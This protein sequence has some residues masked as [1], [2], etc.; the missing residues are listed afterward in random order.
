V[1][2]D[3]QEISYRELNERANRLARH[4]I[5]LGVGPE[6]LVG[7]CFERSVEMVV[8]LIAVSKAGAAWLPL[9]PEY[10]ERRLARIVEAARPKLVLGREKALNRLPSE[11]PCLSLDDPALV[12]AINA[13]CAGVNSD[14]V[15]TLAPRH[16]A[17]VIFTS[18]ST[19][20]PQGV[21]VTHA[22][23]A[24]LAATQSEH[25]R[26]TPRSR[27]LQF[28]SLNFD[29]SVWEMLMAL[30]S[31]ATL[32]LLNEQQRSGPALRE[33]LLSQRITHA[34]LP[35]AVL[36]TLNGD[37]DEAMP[38]ETLV[39]AGEACP[40]ELAA[41]W[42]RRTRMFNAYGPTETTIC[43]T[44]S[45]A[46]AEGQGQVPPI[47]HPI[48]NTQAYVLD[49]NL[50]PAALE[51]VGELYVAG[52][53]L[54]RGYLNHP[55]FTAE[56]FVANP[57]GPSG[58]R[59]YRT[60]DLARRRSDGTLEYVGRADHQVKIRGHRIEPSEVEA[61]LRT[62]PGVAQCAVTPYENPIAGRRLAAWV[63]SMNGALDT[64]SL[65]KTVMERLPD[66]M[67]PA[68]FTILEKLPLTP[69][70]KLDRRALPAPAFS[71]EE[72]R[73]PRTQEEEM[74]CGIFAQL[75]GMERVSIHQSF[76]A[77]GGHSLLAMRL[78]GRVRTAFDVEISLREIY[79]AD[80]PGDLSVL[81]QAI[82]AAAQ[83]AN[84]PDRARTRSNDEF[85][86]KEI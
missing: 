11:T 83:G 66:Y 34:T 9:D 26:V 61:V 31:G 27:V 56:R 16:P 70:G 30:A 86:E 21:V 80:T 4:L 38:L 42:S 52:V 64:A 73:A 46:L 76:F 68:T 79:G 5:R 33:A 59:M 60:G 55:G 43:A 36:E 7:L 65:R 10:P 50:E 14:R 53:S 24:S 84:A 41:K 8:N 3:D 51:V 28:A 44:I 48:V 72:Y 25:L 2:H 85:E 13:E 6:M 1:A 49:S 63:V 54:A 81:I 45:D 39:V 32:V 37:E 20:E 22:G 12:D 67:V 75:L 69:S 23:L 58:T 77:A 19:G 78:S 62:H 74:L 29:A 71:A 47:G 57:Y 35:P 40:G 17:Y 15:Q 82:K 18:G